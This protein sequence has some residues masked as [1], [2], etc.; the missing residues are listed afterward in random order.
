MIRILVADDHAVVREGLKRIIAATTDMMVAGEAVNGQQVL[1]LVGSG[2]WDVVLLDI[3]MPGRGGLDV[4]R[5]LKAEHPRLPV[6]VLSMYSEDQYAVRVLK[7]GGA[8]YLTKDS[9]PEELVNAVR[10]VIR[11]RKYIGPAT[12]ERLAVD[13]DLDFQEAPHEAL[14]D[15]EYQVLCL[16]GSGK[17]VSEIADRL[18]LSVKTISTYRTRILEKMKMNTTAELIRYAIRHNLVE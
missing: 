3:S 13:L 9:A 15:R 18:A 10:R 1:D 7:A 16:L 6:L 11:G 17:T 12:A 8:G 5:Q 2:S 4:L 14:S